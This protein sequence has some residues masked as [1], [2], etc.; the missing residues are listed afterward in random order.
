MIDMRSML[1]VFL[2]AL[3]CRAA[4]LPPPYQN[5]DYQSEDVAYPNSSAAGVLLAGT[6]TRPSG[7]GRFPAVL[8]LTGS[9]PQDRDENILGHKPFLAIADTLSRNGV[10][11]LRTDDRGVGSSTGDWRSANTIDFMS[12]AVAGIRYLESRPYVDSRRIGLLGHSEGAMIAAVLA[13][14]MPDV[15]FV[16][17]LAGSAVPGN[18]LIEEQNYR[19]Q[20]AQGWPPAQ[21]AKEREL[22]HDILDIIEK[23]PDNAAA[24]RQILTLATANGKSPA[25]LMGLGKEL[26]D[27]ML[28]PWF[29]FFI[30]YNP[31]PY[32]E[33]LKCPVLALYGDKDTQVPAVQNA[34][35]LTAAFE[36][37]GNVQAAVEVLPGLNH[38]FQHCD[39]GLPSEYARIKEDI[40]PEVL[41]AIQEWIVKTTRE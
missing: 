27:R 13:A 37:A 17:M 3:C 28:S 39:T 34:P 20:T 23:Q 6:I 7:L 18:Q 35:A 2:I 30:Q 5:S 25:E 41:Q 15:A 40:A 12:D 8:L 29:R 11:V 31:A 14:Q 24:L 10:L 16:V 26:K 38:L 4:A 36:K 32:Y 21:T 33:K 22:L 19:I 1:P 9:G